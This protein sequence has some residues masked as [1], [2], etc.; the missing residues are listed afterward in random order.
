MAAVAAGV[1]ALVVLPAVL[2]G[3]VVR[4]VAGRKAAQRGLDVSI[5]SVGLSG[6]GVSLRD[7]RFVSREPGVV[8]GVVSYARVPL[9]GDELEVH[10]GFIALRGSVDEVRRA[11]GSPAGNTGKASAG[12]GGRRIFADGLAVAWNRSAAGDSAPQRFWGLKLDGRGGDDVLEV[13]L[14]ELGARGVRLEARGVSCRVSRGEARQLRE[15]GVRQAFVRVEVDRLRSEA[16]AAAAKSS[17][18]TRAPSHVEPSSFRTSLLGLARDAAKW[19]P[20]APLTLGEVSA[21]VSY[22]GEQLGFGPSRVDV[23]SDAKTLAVTW[24]PSRAAQA[25][26]TS[27]SLR[28]EVPRHPD[29]PDPRLEVEGGP[30]SL[31]TLGIRDGDFGLSAV[32]DATLEAHLLLSLA[33]RSI[34]FSGSGRLANLSIHRPA[35]SPEELRGIRLGF[36]GRGELATDGSAL[37]LDDGEVT[38]GD[39]KLT[40]NLRFANDVQGMRLAAKGAVPLAS[41]SAMLSSLPEGLVRALGGLK[42]DGVFSLGF[43]LVYDTADVEAMRVGLDVKNE[44]RVTYAPAELNPQRF[45][46][47]WV[48][49]VKGADGSMVPI[50]TGPGTDSWVSYENISRNM[51]IAVQVCE[52]GGFHRHRG[53]DF[54]AMEKAIKDNVRAGRFLRGASTI[55]MQL[56][57]NLYLGKEKTLSRKI[58]EAVL[59]ILLEQ[60]LSKQQILELYLNVIEFGPGIYGIEPASRHYFNQPASELNLSQALYL[61]SILPDPTRPHFASDGSL[62]PSWAAYIQRLIHIAHKVKLISEEE[63]DRALEERIAFRSPATESG[64]TPSGGLVVPESNDP[65]GG[66]PTEAFGGPNSDVAPAP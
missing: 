43:E 9:F 17:P 55:S 48:R 52:D 14:V 39:V 59:T 46:S 44:C 51:E 10:G 63:R 58:E 56:A 13:D 19:L 47:P 27:L 7:A 5:R 12:G 66:A 28:L 61:A 38:F 60:E 2:F 22:H 31:G 8:Q 54:R 26:A 57:K 4:W 33:P 32:R 41:C 24:R 30:V 36:S 34:R 23:S 49:E 1:F 53:F 11:L 35:L 50:E 25:G 65:A 37:A 29:G 62:T 21:S 18:P 6:L 20:E 42:L 3:P 40:G 16:P 64:A 15:L 45:R